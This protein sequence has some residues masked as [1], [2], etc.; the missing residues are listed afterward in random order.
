MDPDMTHKYKLLIS[1]Q[2]L[3][4]PSTTTN[5]VCIH[6]INFPFVTYNQPPL[7]SGG[8]SSWLQ[9]QRPR[10]DSLRYQIFWAV[11]GLE[12][13]PLSLVSTTEGLLE[14][15]SSGFGPESREYGRRDQSRWPRGV[16]SPR[17]LALTSPTSGGLSLGIRRSQTQT[18]EFVC[19]FVCKSLWNQRKQRILSS[20]RWRLVVRWKRIDVSRGHVSSAI[21]IVE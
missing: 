20:G 13:G 18:T 15:K 14:R 4:P 7:W 17:K 19:S 8:Q 9:V 5:S 16:F 2:G 6:V 3:T 1:T 10:F 21:R 12:R 11:V